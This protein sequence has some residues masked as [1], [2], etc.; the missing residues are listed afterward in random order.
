MAAAFGIKAPIKS[1]EALAERE[2]ARSGYPEDVEAHKAVEVENG[3]GP[4]SSKKTSKVSQ[5][6]ILTALGGLLDLLK[7]SQASSALHAL[8]R[9]LLGT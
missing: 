5:Q 8:S 6:P 3:A 1:E 4:T 2:H 7:T 9:M